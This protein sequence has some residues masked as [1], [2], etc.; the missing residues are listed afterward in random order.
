LQQPLQQ[1]QQLYDPVALRRAG[2]A[3]VGSDWRVVCSVG[4]QDGSAVC[5]GLGSADSFGTL[6]ERVSHHLVKMAGQFS[7]LLW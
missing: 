7:G 5:F 4:V 3:V 6:A 1:Q 2:C